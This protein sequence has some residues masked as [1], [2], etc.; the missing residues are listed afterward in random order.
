VWLGRAPRAIGHAD[1]AEAVC[2]G[3]AG[4]LPDGVLER[5]GQVLPSID[6]E[7]RQ[8]LVPAGDVPVERRSGHPQLF[9]DRVQRQTVDAVL[10]NLAQRRGLDLVARPGAPA[11]AAVQRCRFGFGLWIRRHHP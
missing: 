6:D 10:R 3:A 4:V 8:Q 1:R 11:C 5:V 2:R 9:S 7:V